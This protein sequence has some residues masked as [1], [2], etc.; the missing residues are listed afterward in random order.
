M[1]PRSAPEPQGSSKGRALLAMPSGKVQLP[2]SSCQSGSRRVCNARWIPLGPRAG[3]SGSSRSLRGSGGW[4]KPPKAAVPQTSLEME[5]LK[6]RESPQKPQ[7][8]KRSTARKR[9]PN[10]KP[11]YFY[12]K[13][14]REGTGRKPGVATSAQQGSKA[15]WRAD[16]QAALRIC[17]STNYDRRSCPLTPEWSPSSTCFSTK[18]PQH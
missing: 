17:R 8:F 11:S 10:P 1:G 5:P 7:P 6:E 12:L 4:P 9:C 3:Q 15:R 14:R 18:V 13:A 16:P 2:R